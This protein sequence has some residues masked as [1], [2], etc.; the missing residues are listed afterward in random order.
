MTA[1]LL[2]FALVGGLQVGGLLYRVRE[3]PYK[4]SYLPLVEALKKNSPPGSLIMG[5][6]GLWFH[7]LPDRELLQDSNFGCLTGRKPDLIVMEYLF[8]SYHDEARVNLPQCYQH[9]QKVLRS[10]QVVYD[11]GYYQI[12][13]PQW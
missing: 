9:I 12:Y 7:L 13:K 11:D 3:N 6:L 8:K 5:V 4:T 10:A 2:A 1:T